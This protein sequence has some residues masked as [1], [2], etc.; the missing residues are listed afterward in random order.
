[1][2]SEDI[3]QLKTRY[4]RYLD[5]KDWV[6][7]ETLFATDAVMDFRSATGQEQDETALISGAQNF[8]AFARDNL[9]AATTLHHGY[10]PEIE[11]TSPTTAHGV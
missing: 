10:M 9:N 1:L 7:F 2:P 4:F 8:T 5:A 11:T 6:G 3:R